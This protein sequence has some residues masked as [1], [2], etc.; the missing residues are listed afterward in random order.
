MASKGKTRTNIKKRRKSSGFTKILKEVV[1]HSNSKFQIDFLLILPVFKSDVDIT[2][3]WCKVYTS[4]AKKCKPVVEVDKNKLI[5][6]SFSFNKDNKYLLKR[7]YALNF[8]KLAAETGSI[9]KSKYGKIVGTLN[10]FNEEKTIVNEIKECI[11]GG[12]KIEGLPKKNGSFI[13]ILTDRAKLAPSDNDGS[14]T[15]RPSLENV[16]KLEKIDSVAIV[17]E[18]NRKCSKYF[19]SISSHELLKHTIRENSNGCPN[20]DKLVALFQQLSY[21]VPTEIIKTPLQKD[22]KKKLVK[23]ISI[24]YGLKKTNNFFAMMAIYAGLSNRSISRVDYLWNS[25]I[26]RIMNDFGT[27]FNPQ[28]SYK[29]YRNTI[30]TVK[31]GS[32]VVPLIPVIKQDLMHILEGE[33]LK[34]RKLNSALFE[35][36][37]A[38]VN[39]FE[40]Y[41][42]P[43]RIEKDT[44]LAYYFKNLVIWSSDDRLYK[45]SLQ[46]FSKPT[47][48]S[49]RS[50]RGGSHIRLRRVRKKR[51]GSGIK[52]NTNN[53]GSSRKRSISFADVDSDDNVKPKTQDFTKWD[54][55]DVLAW[56]QNSGLGQY[57]K[58]F[59]YHCI[60]GECLSELDDSELE[61]ELGIKPYEHRICFK[62]NVEDLLNN[63]LNMMKS[64]SFG[65]TKELS[66]LN[67]L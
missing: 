52:I 34:S 55:D 57:K 40:S 12:L 25:K 59:K 3:I 13:Q 41:K 47:I 20:M 35:S 62:R 23:F 38:L 51:N 65:N 8:M 53:S 32:P 26:N 48:T 29:I 5:T 66:N 24:L 43:Y 7:L 44:T 37:A 50:M 49:S 14:L 39:D 19:N 67:S 33:I 56:L 58:H 28:N 10:K 4:V 46:M 54:N 61:Q 63:S 60:T 42:I 2:N 21:W 9:P 16:R 11:L 18:I 64:V 1:V 22:Q 27:L 30:K 15:D 6:K 36:L 31:P 45:Y 17:N